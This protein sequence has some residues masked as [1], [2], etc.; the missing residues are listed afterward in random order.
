MIK[1]STAV[2]FAFCTLTGAGIF[3]LNFQVRAL[4]DELIGT[5]HQINLAREDLRHLRT[6]WTYLNTP[7]RIQVLA[8]THLDLTPTKMTQVIS[9]DQLKGS[10]GVE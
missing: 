6:E 1:P 4:E 3:Y 9:L 10:G 2:C 5:N 8:E 7:A